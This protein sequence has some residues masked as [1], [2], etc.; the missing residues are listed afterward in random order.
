M[1]KTH[2]LYILLSALFLLP[3]TVGAQSTV[4]LGEE[5][6]SPKREARAVWLTTLSGLDWP[7]TKA[8]SA[9]SRERQ[10]AELCDILDR[11]QRIHVN[12]I[13]L[14]TRVR[15]STIYPSQIEPWDVALTGSYG[16]DPGYDPLQFAIE[17]A[18]R[19]GMELHAWVVTMPAYKIAVAK[20]M[21]KAALHLKH[22]ALMKKHNDQYYLDPSQPATADYLARICEEIVSR[23]DVDGIHFDYIRYPEGAKG[24][25]DDDSYKRYG[26][27]KSK[28]QWRRD[29]ITHIVRTIHQRVKA[30]K[31]WVR[32]TSSP[33]GKF[34]DL[35]RY[36][37]RG[38]NCYDAVHQDAQGW[39]REGIHDAL[40]PMMYFKGDNFYP[41][42]TDWREQDA[43][44]FVAPGL[45]IYFMDRAEKNWPLSDIV[46]ELH[47]TRSLGLGGQCYFRTR[48][49]LDN[50]KGLYDYLRDAFYAFPAL[51]PAATW[52]D[53][54]APS[55]PDGFATDTLPDGRVRLS[56][57]P[58]TDNLHGAASLGS[59]A[60]GV[61]YNV[62]A[63]QHR[64]DCQQ[65]EAL[66]AA[67]LCEPCYVYNPHELEARG[68]RLMVAAMDRCGNE[69]EAV[70][71]VPFADADKA[72]TRVGGC[73]WDVPAV[74]PD[75]MGC[76]VL[77]RREAAFYA[78]TDLAGHI[79]Q[80]GRYPN[81]WTDSGRRI[82]LSDLPDGWLELRTLLKKGRSRRVLRV[83]KCTPT[84]LSLP[85]K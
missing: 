24:F 28:A 54:E 14:Q 33:V 36:S 38:W 51:T 37:A 16:G 65:A 8:T 22:P 30:L 40:Y 21:G 66:V 76:I 9:A 64:Q 60:A 58:C 2:T 7:R 25:A 39:L 47:Y 45:G 56:W 46:N 18:H 12:T 72:P 11:L 42:A 31:P 5:A 3:H 53:D 80:T 57:L 10:K 70:A 85:A 79:L 83:W 50:V 59:P 82:D 74:E 34:R 26:A 13:L 84:R 44:R 69:S 17:E 43:G 48:F 15:A 68:L 67:A 62:Y 20:Q 32:V 63:V 19:R 52:I 61:R 4:R 29:N 73:G 77:P 1:I 35:K 75:S 78:I 27:G 81:S 55:Q 71:P 49:L 6:N 41:F 23:Y